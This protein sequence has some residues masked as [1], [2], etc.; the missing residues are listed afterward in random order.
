MSST[1]GMAAPSRRR[2]LGLLAAGGTALLSGCAQPPRA[3]S[4]AQRGDFW[5]GRLAVQ[6]EGDAARSFSAG[7][8]LAGSASAGS[9]LLYT[10]LGNA[11]AELRWTPQ[12]AVLKQGDRERSSTSL[13]QLARDLTGVDLPIEA[14][15]AWL[16]GDAVQ[17]AGWQ[18]DLSRLQDGRLVASRHAPEPQ[19][20]LRVVLER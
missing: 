13:Q 20:T 9:L 18:A 10:P 19:A 4:D 17:A 15:F 11:L 8:T 14:L 5:S 3:A 1:A 6:V 16:H 2:W 7:F 12:H